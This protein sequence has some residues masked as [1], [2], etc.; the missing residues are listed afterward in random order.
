MELQ[1]SFFFIAFLI[2]CALPLLIR[3]LF[4]NSDRQRSN[5]PPSPPSLPFLGHLHLIKQPIHRTLQSIS[6]KYGK[7]LYLQFGYRRVLLLSSLS[8]VEE[9]FT[10]H[11]LAFAS[12]PRLLAGKYFNY[13]FTTV[14]VAPYGDHWRNLR[15][16]L[17]SEL[18]SS[19]SLSRFSV[20]RE[21][22]VRSS[23][24][25][26][27][28]SCVDMN[29]K[30]IRLK[31]EIHELI[32]N[33]MTMVT[34]GKRFYGEGIG[35]LEE[36][37]KFQE[38]MREVIDLSGSSNLGD[39]LP[40]LQRIDLFG[41]KK[42]M[43]GLMMKMDKFLQDLVDE[44]RLKVGSFMEKVV[45]DDLL[46]LQQEE[47]ELLTNDILKGIVLVILTAGTDT[48]STTLEWAMALLLNHPEA[49]A[50]LRAEIDAEVGQD[51]LLKEEDLPKLKYLQN[52]ID[53]TLRLYPAAPLLGLRE[54]SE[55]CIVGGY[56]I[57]RGAIL[58]VNAWAI[59]RD[60]EVWMNP[61]EFV[62]ERW[63]EE[64]S[65]KKLIAFG[66][67]RRGCP[68]VMVANRVIGLALGCMIQVFNWERID[69]EKIDMTEALGL[70]MPRV[71]PL[72]VLCKSRMKL[73]S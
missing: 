41:T 59:H 72:D 32:F 71:N 57:D 36:A 53:E 13:D 4:F 29:G 42:K 55:D 66:G 70:T 3:S 64:G 31:S 9:C 33:T 52:V 10:K 51:R 24:E 12:R 16:V 26:I 61:T 45:I 56:E 54:A 63:D 60:S 43:V 18:F 65:Y 20:V 1:L 7:V 73:W 50:K 38:V 46:A 19:P 35:E 62:P 67:G 48:S 69:D 23:I 25:R 47:P 40:I 22:E 37:K 17:T 27:A 14:I 68:G 11:D 34:L 39:F 5:R 15:R 21:G 2:T 58:M 6:A 8:A 44:H 30:K 28:R 49:M